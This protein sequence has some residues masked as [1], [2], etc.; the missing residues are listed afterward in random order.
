MNAPL[1]AT[2]ALTETVAAA[3][4]AR[5]PLYGHTSLETAYHIA[6]YP[7]GFRLRCEMKAWLEFKKGKGYRFVTMTSNPKKPGTWNKPKASTYVDFAA[8]MY[9][10][11]EGHIQWTGASPYG[12][13]DAVA[14]FAA[15]FP[16]MPEEMRQTLLGWSLAN[17]KARI[18]T[19]AGIRYMTINGERCAYS[20]KDKARDEAER[21][22][23][24][25][26]I[27]TLRAL[28]PATTPA[29]V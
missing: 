22:A 5:T 18:E 23:W 9:L 1:A 25:A 29:A 13:A 28:A 27:V 16:A 10:D 2:A 20:D 19:I 12:G 4:P 6:D 24:E 21:D 14:K 15:L 17:R 11:H 7:Y 26:V 8:G 3:A